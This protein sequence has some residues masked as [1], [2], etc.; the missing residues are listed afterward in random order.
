MEIFQ[1]AVFYLEKLVSVATSQ[2]MTFFNIFSPGDLRRR[3][4][5]FV[6]NISQRYDEYVS[7]CMLYCLKT[8][9]TWMMC[10][11]TAVIGYLL[12]VRFRDQHYA[13]GVG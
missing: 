1:L 9:F 12:N 2:P 3:L 6:T 8:N 11:W 10:F 13:F 4:T 7:M 5:K